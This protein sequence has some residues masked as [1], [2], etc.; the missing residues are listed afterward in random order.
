MAMENKEKQKE[1]NDTNSLFSINNKSNFIS[2][3]YNKI[4]IDIINNEETFP[5]KMMKYLCY[6]FAVVTIILMTIEFF[7]QKSAFERLAYLLNQNLYFA[8]T[9]I[10][11]AGLYTIGV[12]IRWLSHS[13][14]KDSN[15]HLNQK[16][17]EFLRNLLEKNLAIMEELK[18][19]VSSTDEEFREIIN[20]YYE[21]EVYFYKLDEPQ[22]YKYNIKNIFYSMVNNE[23]K[24]MNKFDYFINDDCKE[25]P[26]ELGINEV[27]LKNMIE[28]TYFFYN[29]D[30]KISSIEE[31]KKSKKTDKYFFYFPFSLIISAAILLFLLFFFIY[32]IISLFNMEIY[33]LDK[34]INFNS[35]NFD[36]YLKKLDE[37]KKKLRNDTTEEEDKGD[38]MNLKDDEDGEGTNIA[39]KKQ[40]Q[41]SNKT[42]NKKKDKIKHNKIQQQRKKKLKVMTKYFRINLILFLIKLILILFSSM[43]YYI[44]CMFLKSK[45]KNKFFDFYKINEAIDKVFK[46]SLDIYLSLKRKIE[47]YENS[48]IN[49]EKIGDFEEIKVPE[50]GEI[51]TPKFGNVIMEI[52]GDSDI[53]EK[54]KKDFSSLFEHNICE[55]VIENESDMKHCENFWFGVLL[56]GMEQAIVQMDVILSS[57]LDELKSLNDLNNKTLLGLMTK[58]S[59]IEYSQFNEYY[60][61]KVYDKAYELLVEM[62]LQKLNSIIKNFRLILLFYLLISFFLFSLMIFFVYNFNALFNS[63]LNFIG[64]FPP[65]YLYEDE[66]FYKEIVKFGEKYF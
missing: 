18:T 21:F 43:T 58:S 39:E 31:Y 46:D 15:T 16:W 32:Y 4:K 62:R 20:N 5:L 40:L 23:I 44:L 52:N 50:V 36:I 47:I 9:K 45:Y 56:K 60:L 51:N 66:N 6:I 10:N 3:E 35:S 37:I 61:I 17:S 2:K 38:D 11:V 25:I 54:T 57:V 19:T 14:F 49:C 26:K 24:I 55:E 29:L 48:L 42:K 64:I 27:N 22:K 34:L 65:K 30:L 59:L 28:Q 1:F 63:F 13:L 12:N 53:E 41:D 8:E 33:F 7:Q